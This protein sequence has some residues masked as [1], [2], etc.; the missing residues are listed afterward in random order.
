MARLASSLWTDVSIEHRD[1]FQ[2]HVCSHLLNGAPLLV[3]KIGA[4]ELNL[5]YWLERLV[6]P[7][8][9]FLRRRLHLWNLRSCETNAGLKPRTRPSYRQFALL[10]RQAALEADYVGVWH[11]D[12]EIL[13]YRQ[14]ALKA[15]FYDLFDI[16]PWFASSDCAWSMALAGRKVFVVSPFLASIQSQYA[17]RELIWQSRPGLLPDFQLSGYQFPYLISQNCSLTWQ[18]VYQD[19][20]EAIRRSQ[21]DVVLLGCG[22]LGLPIGME[23]R[24]LGCQAL[25]LGGFLQVLFGIHG[26]RFRRDPA[27]RDLINEHWIAPSSEETPR[28]AGRIEGGCYW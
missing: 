11:D 24:R 21:C 23:A 27:Y 3:G 19:V 8:R 14:L 28:E 1:L 15:G 12:A 9:P 13:L 5:L 20:V 26:G 7:G 25:H 17:R 2:H 22:A 16:C 6:V 18:S 10:L 4:N